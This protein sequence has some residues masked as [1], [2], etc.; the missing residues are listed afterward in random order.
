MRLTRFFSAVFFISFF[1]ASFF[2]TAQTPAKPAPDVITFTNGDK[3][4]GHFVR[5]TAA[6]VTFHSDAVGDITVDWKNVKELETN[7]KVALIRK[8]VELRHRSDSASIPQGILAMSD[9]KLT[10]TPTPAAAP[11]PVPVAEVATVI[12]QPTFQKAITHNPSFLKDWKG[13]L[14]L[15][16]SLVAATQDSDTLNGALGLV[17]MEPAENWLDPR[18][19]TILNFSTSFG[20]IKQTG[21]PTVRTSIYHLDVERDEYVSHKLYVFASGAFDHNFSQGLELQET[22]SGGAGYTILSA[23]N[24]TLDVKGSASYL[25]QQFNSIPDQSLVGSVF[26]QHYNRKLAHGFVADEHL[27]Y[28]PAW[29]VTRAWSGAFNTVLTMPVYKRLSSSISFIDS[30]LNDPPPGFKKNS[31]QLSL[32]ATWALQ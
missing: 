19:R 14:T 23:P 22:Y 30:F 24:Q 3:L 5:S 6:N 12:D 20:E 16:A 7:T 15:G 28:T 4:A 9:Q 25:R 31:V 17:R 13:T 21:T 26:A 32:G 11:Q 2:A 29:N 8:G 27:T 1:A 10:L 18:D